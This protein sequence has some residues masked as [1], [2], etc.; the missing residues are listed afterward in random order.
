MVPEANRLFKRPPASSQ[1]WYLDRQVARCEIAALAAAEGGSA[2][3]DGDPLQPVW[4]GWI[5]AGE[6]W[7]GPRAALDFFGERARA[8]ALPL[9]DRYVLC[10][11]DEQERAA[12][13]FARERTRGLDEARARA[14]VARYA[15][16]AEPQRQYFAALAAAFP[17]WIEIV[18][19]RPP[20]AEVAEAIATLPPSAAP[21]ATDVVAA[22]A[23]WFA[24]L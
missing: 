4:F 3:L 7:I 24:G 15:A 6:G 17:G 11:L 22:A 20:A 14:K 10:T 13:M 9:P 18:D 16:M 21:P 1:A 5:Y 12:R 19:T 8:G 2:V 23:G